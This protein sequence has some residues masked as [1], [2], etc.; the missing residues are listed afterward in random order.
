ML[1]SFP[2]HGAEERRR[3]FSALNENWFPFL[4]RKSFVRAFSFL[5]RPHRYSFHY[6]AL[7]LSDSEP[8]GARDALFLSSSTGEQY[9]P[10]VRRK[11]LNK[12]GKLL[13]LLRSDRAAHSESSYMRIQ[14]KRPFIDLF[15]C[16]FHKNRSVEFPPAVSILAAVR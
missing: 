8:L 3:A 1:A 13:K 2:I 14:A 15:I 6:S 9:P 16:R 7:V 10:K 4:S 12:N 11:N 5:S